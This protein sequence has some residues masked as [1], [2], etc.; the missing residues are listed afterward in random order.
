MS[1]FKITDS[2]FYNIADI[3]DDITE[4]H[5]SENI[6]VILYDESNRSLDFF[7][8]EKTKVSYFGLQQSEKDK[9]E[10][11]FFQN[12]QWSDL[13]ISSL[14][15]SKDTNNLDIKMYSKLSA[16]NTS[17]DM[18]VLS[19]IW[20]DWFV[21]LDWIIEIDKDLHNCSG[22]LAEE[23]IFLGES[24]KAKGIPTLLI[25]SDDVQASHSCKMDRISDERLFYLR[26]RG[27]EK[28]DSLSMM[29]ESYTKV[30]FRWLKE[31]QEDFYEAKNEY[32]LSL[33]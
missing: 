10:K 7:L 4:I 5:F 27:I 23:N 8:W 22:H 32:I 14:L 16:D 28:E 21:A 3:A 24:W 33:I 25:S 12:E 17:T 1:I 18:N 9:I 29:I 26:S 31:N 30:L 15:L 20:N 2:G 13:K 11:R 6:E 19:F